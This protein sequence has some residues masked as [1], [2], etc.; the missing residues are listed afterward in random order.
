MGF[1]QRFP[2]TDDHQ[3]N[4]NWLVK[5]WK[6]LAGGN[7]GQVLKK[8]SNKDYDW[9]W[10]VVGGGGGT[11]DYND[12]SNKPSINGNELSG[13]KTTAQLGIS[14]PTPGTAFPAMDGTAS[15]G[16]SSN[17]A[18]AD[19]VHPT[20]SSR[21]AAY[22]IPVAGTATPAMDGTGSAGSSSN[23]SRADHV[24]PT[25]TSRAAASA[26][27]AA[28]TATP[29]MDGTGSAGSSS[30]Y[31]RADHVHPTDTSRAAASSVHSIPSGGS[32]GQVLAKSSNTD[33]DVAWV[34]G[35]G[36]G[37]SPYTSNPEALGTAAPGSS[38]NYS[39]GDHVHAMPTAAD[40]GAMAE[41]TLLWTNP[42]PTNDFIGQTISVPA[43]DG[44]DMYLIMAKNY[45]TNVNAA[46]TL[47]IAP[48]TSDNE[49]W[50]FNA[51][52]FHGR[53]EISHTA[54]SFTFGACK[55][56][57]TY[58]NATGTTTNA[59]LIPYYIYGIKGVN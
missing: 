56:Y 53:T 9:E 51:V 22:A 47:F 16:S 13:N 42:D 18:R 40:V 5:L 19:H 8:R 29:A 30:D 36:G 12:L 23:Y 54:G 38:D 3:L 48:A 11:S 20:D 39:R 59:Y 17:Y 45:K 7:T 58:G 34:T 43:A 6:T 35:G 55:T 4:L 46:T 50:C 24:H 31:S 33:Y 32:S 26:I 2:Y 41:W 15:A 10:E 49:L 14:I 21:A 52:K 27:P 28:S 25:D 37:P 1:F 44:Y 57:D